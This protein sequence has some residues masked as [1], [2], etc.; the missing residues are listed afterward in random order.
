MTYDEAMAFWFGRINYEVRSATP[1]DLK[2]ERMRALLRLLDDPHER[3]RIVHV[4]GTKGKGST[5]AMLASILRSAGYR[6]G[7]YTS[8][9]LVHV[10]ERIRVNETPISREELTAGMEAIAPAVRKLEA[11]PWAPPTF[12]EIS[13]ALG[14][15]HFLHRR[16]DVAVVEVGLGGR[17]DSTNVCRPLVAIITSIG[18]DHMAQLGNTPEAI[19]FQKAGIIKPRIPT[20]SGVT[21]PGPRAVIAEVAASQGSPLV[22]VG[23][24]YQTEYAPA[25][26]DGPAQVK[27]LTRARATDW[28][29]LGLLGAHQAANAGVAVATVERL[30]EAGLTITEAA[31]ARGL[32]EVRWP[33]RIEVLRRQPAIVLDCAHNEPSALAL[34][35]TLRESL[36]IPGKKIVILGVSSDKPYA[37]MLRHFAGYFDRFVLTRYGNNPRSVPPERLRDVL[38][39][40]GW[41][42]EIRCHATAQEAWQASRAELGPDD[43]LCATGSVFLAGELEGRMREDQIA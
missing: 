1:T 26:S 9:H 23:T 39:E 35:Q 19:A 15:W 27:V 16:V 41:A 42:G 20:V 37:E 14:F 8:P 3:L 22:Q 17:F 21:Q 28:L 12:F 5:S 11:G 2:L 13:T 4:T 24:D 32:A 31:L 30:R 29:R 40:Q 43:L 6:V 38:T 36:P 33:A 25:T 34:V 18:M 7:L 10:E